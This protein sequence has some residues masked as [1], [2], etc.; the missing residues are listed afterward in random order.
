[1]IR[2]DTTVPTSPSVGRC[3][4]DINPE[5]RTQL[6]LLARRPSARTT[7]FS[8]REPTDWRPSQVRRPGG[9]F[10]PYF[11][12][13]AAWDLIADELE[14]GREVEVVELHRPPGAKGYVMK[15]ELERDAP[16]LYVKLQLRPGQVVGRSFHYSERS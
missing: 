11:T 1:M 9:G 7:A 5:T 12:D 14:D 4:D 15:I 10:S 13:A 2:N 6:A 8:R 16:T 3:H